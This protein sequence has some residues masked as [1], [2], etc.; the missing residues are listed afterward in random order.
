MKCELIF[1][2]DELREH[3]KLPKPAALVIAEKIVEYSETLNSEDLVSPAFDGVPTTIEKYLES[4][5]EKFENASFKKVLDQIAEFSERHDVLVAANPYFKN[6]TFYKIPEDLRDDLK[7]ASGQEKLEALLSSDVVPVY[8]CLTEGIVAVLKGS[9]KDARDA[10]TQ[11]LPKHMDGFLN[12]LR[13]ETKSSKLVAFCAYSAAVSELL[14]ENVFFEY[15]GQTISLGEFSEEWEI[16]SGDK[17][18]FQRGLKYLREYFKQ[19]I[20]ENEGSKGE[21]DKI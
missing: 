3:L 9:I 5:R 15:D 13:I 14:S 11:S 16:L 1:S 4:W 2:V 12:D 7:E 17:E 10:F 20:E 18:A 6:L 19:V 21:E 8:I